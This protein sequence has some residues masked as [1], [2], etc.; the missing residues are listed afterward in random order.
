MCW[1]CKTVFRLTV[2]SIQL[3]LQKTED[4]MLFDIF[5]LKKGENG[6]NLETKPY[7]F[8]LPPKSKNDRTCL[9]SCE[10]P[11]TFLS[12]RDFLI[13]NLKQK[14]SRKVLGVGKNYPPH[15]P[16]RVKGV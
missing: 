10:T 6:R 1:L 7:F 2:S 12:P 4:F 3:K 16:A 11:I 5:L 14:L 9:K 15:G 8:P 13:N